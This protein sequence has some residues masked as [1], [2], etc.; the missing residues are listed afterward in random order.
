MGQYI[1]VELVLQMSFRRKN[2]LIKGKM[3]FN[4]GQ[5]ENGKERKL[6]KMI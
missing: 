2:N 5:S 3:H 1:N 6:F 4:C